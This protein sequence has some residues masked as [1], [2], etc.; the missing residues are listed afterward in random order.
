MT[1]SAL[2][3]RAKTLL[4]MLGLVGLVGGGMLAG[5]ELGL[6]QQ[7]RDALAADLGGSA[8]SFA[9]SLAAGADR[10]LAEGRVVAEE[11]RLKATMGTPGID[12]A[13]LED[14]ADELRAAVGWDLLALVAADGTVVACR[15]APAPDSLPDAARTALAGSP[16]AGYWRAG[17]GAG[18]FQ[19]AAVP[20]AFGPRVIG[21]LVAG[22]AL[23]DAWAAR[24]GG[25]A[26]MP[27]TLRAASGPLASSLPAGSAVRAAAE[28]LPEPAPVEAELA[29]ERFLLREVELAGGGGLRALLFRS[30]DEAFGP[31]RSL[32]GIVFGVT[33]LAFLLA[34]AAAWFVSRGLS[35]PVKALETRAEGLARTQGVLTEELRYARD[36]QRSILPPPPRVDG[37]ETEATYRPLGHVGGDLYDLDVTDGGDRLLALVV[38]AT[39]HG[40]AAGLT[41]MLIKAQ[42]DEL[43]QSTGR[44]RELL[45]ALNDR[46]ARDY[47]DLEVRF[48]AVC[49]SLDLRDGLLRWATAAHTGPCIVRGGEL[50][51][52]EGGGPFVGLVPGEVYPE[53]ETRLAPGDGF[54]L[55]TDGLTEHW[56]GAGEIFG[57]ARLAAAIADAHARG[58]AAGPEAC[59]RLAAF[60]G[61]GGADALNDD[62]TLVGVRLTGRR[63]HARAA[64]AEGAT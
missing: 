18:V 40:V 22:T 60:A 35:A 61:A 6:R 43:K 17:A 8:A 44:P 45:A 38:D 14:V 20:L 3:F 29:G 12:R 50:I 32:R 7:L 9:E 46:M 36:F 1:Y 47:G 25:R 54:Y 28:A 52:S 10:L 33:A 21:A 19:V 58:A 2:S 63:A 37:A 53:R 27:V 23:S 51:E 34:V 56:N 16:V 57:E 31:Y 11:P 59:A 62:A 55:Y 42:Y 24:I 48:T 15:G 49:A 39:G 26:H 5:I 41:T 30:E 64:A 13:T 4:A